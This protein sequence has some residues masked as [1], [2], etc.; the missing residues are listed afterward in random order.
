[1]TIYGYEWG[2]APAAGGNHN[3]YYLKKGLPLFRSSG[4]LTFLPLNPWVYYSANDIDTAHILGLFQRLKALPGVQT[5]EV[6]V[7]PHWRGGISTPRWQDPALEPL[8]EV[9]SEAGFHEAWA[10]SFMTPGIHKGFMGGAT[11]IW[12]GPGMD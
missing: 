7:I 6:M 10:Q 2:G 11:I 5:G 12:A 9:A 8:I 4:L 3:V 1:M